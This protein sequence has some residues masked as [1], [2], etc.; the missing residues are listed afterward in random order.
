MWLFGQW[1]SCAS[2]YGTLPQYAPAAI[3]LVQEESFINVACWSEVFMR[4]LVRHPA[5]AR[6]GSNQ[7]N[8]RGVIHQSGLGGQW[9]ACASWYGTLPQH[10]PAA[11]SL[12]QEGS[13]INVACWAVVV[14]RKL[15]RHP[16][17]ARSCNNQSSAKYV[18]SRLC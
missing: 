9:W 11:I 15:V 16:A 14:L 13:F 1:W 4:Q 12:V 2:W 10:A 6:A 18:Y 8:A 7:S 5:S 3:S 17:S